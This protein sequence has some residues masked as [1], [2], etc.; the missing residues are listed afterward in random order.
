MF[1]RHKRETLTLRRDLGLFEAV[2]A[3][4]GIIVGAGIYVLIGAAAGYAGNAV[5]LSFVISAVVALLTGLS[6]AE[7]S[8]IYPE[9]SGEYSY[10]EHNFNKKFAF[11]IGYLVV[12][13]LVI[14]AAAVSLGFA[15]YLGTVL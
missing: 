11:V 2:L 7:L 9:A 10:V 12:F 15:G 3:G 13:S 5:W 6:Y 1:K 8:S 14:G 4:V